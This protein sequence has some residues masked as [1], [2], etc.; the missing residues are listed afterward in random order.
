M[1]FCRPGYGSGDIPKIKSAD[2]RSVFLLEVINV[3]FQ[4]NLNLNFTITFRY[5]DVPKCLA[6]LTAIIC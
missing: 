4:H 5:M 1:V 3:D 2:I 6:Q